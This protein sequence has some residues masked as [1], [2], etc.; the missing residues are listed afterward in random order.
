MSLTSLQQSLRLVLLVQLEGRSPTMRTWS[1]QW[2]SR[3]LSSQNFSSDGF[4][5]PS[6]SLFNIGSVSTGCEFAVTSL[7][8][9]SLRSSSLHD[10]LPPSSTPP[11]PRMLLWRAHGPI[12]TQTLPRHTH[13]AGSRQYPSLLCFG[14]LARGSAL[15]THPLARVSSPDSP[16]SAWS[17]PTLPRSCRL[18]WLGV[19]MICTPLRLWSPLLVPCVRHIRRGRTPPSSTLTGSGHSPI[20]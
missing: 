14:I 2:P 12:F 4:M 1:L 15:S 20:T 9:L 18:S 11:D 17:S 13:F 6:P 3:S 5:P 19:S 10:S 7:L 8:P 16:S